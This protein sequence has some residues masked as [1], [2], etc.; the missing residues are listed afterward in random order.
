MCE[1]EVWFEGLGFEVVELRD[2][3][4]DWDFHKLYDAINHLDFDLPSPLKCFSDERY[5]AYIVVPTN[6]LH[7][8]IVVGTPFKDLCGYTGE[9]LA[10]MIFER[11]SEDWLDLESYQTSKGLNS[12]SEVEFKKAFID[13][14][15]DCL[16]YVNLC[17]KVSAKNHVGLP[18]E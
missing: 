13:T 6:T 8:P 15:S 5:G 18:R 11:L 9:E 14:I 3:C 7:S 4:K 2:F 10:E 12:L 1:K 17:Y 16:Y